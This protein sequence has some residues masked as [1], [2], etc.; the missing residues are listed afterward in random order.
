MGG[1]ALKLC[2]EQKV[3]VVWMCSA[4][5]EKV[6][7]SCGVFGGAGEIESEEV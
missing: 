6:G 5:G 4:D 2:E 1:F 7:H 3:V